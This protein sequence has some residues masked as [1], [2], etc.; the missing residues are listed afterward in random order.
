MNIIGCVPRSN[1][2]LQTVDKVDSDVALEYINDI[3]RQN[4]GNSRSYFKKAVILR[5]RGELQSAL[6][7]VDRAI[8][9]EY[10]DPRFF[11]F[12]GEILTDLNKPLAAIDL[13][14]KAEAAGDRNRELY[15][16]LARNYLQM[17]QPLEARQAVDKLLKIDQG[18]LSHVLAGKAYLE[19]GDTLLAAKAFNEA[20]RLNSN[21]IDAYG[22][23]VELYESQ[24]RLV[25]AEATLDIAL[26]IAPNN[27]VFLKTKSKYLKNRDEYDSALIVFKK[28]AQL[29][30]GKE[31]YLD[32]ADVYYA[33]N[34]FDSAMNYI[35]RFL[36]LS[37]EHPQALLI[38][39][40]ILDRT[41]N[42]RDAEEIYRQILQNDSTNNLALTE[43]D[44]LKRKVSYL[45][46]L[47]RQ[48]QALDSARNNLP[49]A[50]DRKG[51][52]N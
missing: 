28:V 51:L 52:E 22:G 34:R 9:I 25:L 10:S 29:T 12:K 41:R 44:K 49:P 3:S 20:I 8:Q 46:R 23:L 18:D 39:A 5:Q 33:L 21:N 11:L 16:L 37:E 13:L 36:V 43:L 48:R 19:L 27:L 47:E 26:G 31:T 15:S 7:S 50:L 1:D 24:G 35:D 45:Q 32:L 6:E 14:L 38:K 42:Y 30:Q 4:P 2:P 40:R 17:G